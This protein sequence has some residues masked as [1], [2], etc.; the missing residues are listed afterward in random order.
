MIAQ[1]ERKLKA[2]SGLSHRAMQHLCLPPPPLAGRLSRRPFATQAKPTAN[3]PWRDEMVF[4]SLRRSL[5]A[6]LKD[7]LKAAGTARPAFVLPLQPTH[8][9]VK[10]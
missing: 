7:P 2:E 4:S 8:S 3:D 9:C 5:G 6:V 10:H 1:M